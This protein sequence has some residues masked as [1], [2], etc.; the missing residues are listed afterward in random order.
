M[1]KHY[2]KVIRVRGML[3]GQFYYCTGHYHR[4]IRT[5]AEIRANIGLTADAHWDEDH[6]DLNIRPRGRRNEWNLDAWNDRKVSRSYKKSWKDFT[7]HEK[8]WMMGEEPPAI[9]W[10]EWW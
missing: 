6:R 4:P 7:K 8:Q 10:D 2:K 3:A 5:A 9:S 1:K